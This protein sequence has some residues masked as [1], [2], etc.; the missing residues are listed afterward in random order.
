MDDAYTID[1]APRCRECGKL[2]A[3]NV[4]RPWTIRCPR[5]KTENTGTSHGHPRE[6]RAVRS[7]D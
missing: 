4:A 6:T 2:L 7:A 1:V 3:V 5:C